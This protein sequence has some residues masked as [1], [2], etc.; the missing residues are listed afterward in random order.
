M[1]NETKNKQ[2]IRNAKTWPQDGVWTLIEQLLDRVDVLEAELQ[3]YKPV[4][5]P[6]IEREKQ[7]KE[8]RQHIS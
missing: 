2:L 8:F 1:E 5:E 7:R 6:L 4:L 3:K